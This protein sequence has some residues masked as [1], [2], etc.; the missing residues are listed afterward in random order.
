MV[1]A[2]LVLDFILLEKLSYLWKNRGKNTNFKTSQAKPTN[3]KTLQWR[4]PFQNR[5]TGD[6]LDKS[7]LLITGKFIER[8]GVCMYK[9][10]SRYSTYKRHHVQFC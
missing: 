2:L 9:D 5:F 4:F 10:Y 8:D 7:V 1:Y 6:P 3:P